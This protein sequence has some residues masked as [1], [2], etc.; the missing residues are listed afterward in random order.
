MTRK[1]KKLSQ[2]AYAFL[3]GTLLM[4]AFAP[5]SLFPLAVI[6]PV[7]LC[8]LL[9][10]AKTERSFWLG[11]FFGIGLFSSGVYWVFISINRFGDVP[12]ILAGLITAALIAFLAIFPAAS[13][14]YATRYFKSNTRSQFVFALPGIWVLFEWVRSWLFTGFPWLIIGYSQTNSPLKGYA[15][16]LS[17]FGISL[18]LMV[19]S[20]LIFDTWIAYRQRAKRTIAINCTIIAALWIVGGL[21]SLIP[22]TTPVGKP[23]TVSLVQGNIPQSLKW[24]PENVALSFSRYRDLSEPLFGKADLIIWPESALPMAMQ[25]A[26]G[27]INDIASKARD[28]NTN[29]LFGIPVQNGDKGYFNALV[30]VGAHE[31]HYEKRQLV[32]FGEYVPFQRLFARAFDF[33]N[34]PMSNMIKGE[35]A[36]NT[37]QLG[38]INI[39]PAI[40]YEIAYPDLI[41]TLDD[42][43]N[44][45]L[46]VTNDAW[47]G[48]STAQA[49]HLQMAAM[50]SLELARTGLFVSN[51]GI[52]AIINEKG[53]IESAAPAHTTYVLK[54]TA[55]RFTGFTPWMRN[56][57]DPVLTFIL[58]MLIAAYRERYA[59]TLKP[60]REQ[61][62]TTVST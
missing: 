13:C 23:L 36:Q 2:L 32:P 56:G 33:M 59:A 45:I 18:V 17:V 14:A 19:T 5:F 48:E 47:F 61:H 1:F 53:Q 40:C 46:T 11:Y 50:R 43:V 34:V 28:T 30:S 51:D 27:Y 29:L 16:L 31:A 35:H 58:V 25:D 54:G 3:L 55:Q 57:L 39:L 15:P 4:F 44:L 7:G 52:T 26:T 38:D 24:D 8:A 60:Q 12:S 62:A 10:K 42:N 37:L 6:A 9:Y 21:T 22:W 49:Q 20:G 41:R